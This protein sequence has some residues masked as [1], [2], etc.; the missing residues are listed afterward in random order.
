MKRELLDSPLIKRALD[1]ID[2]G[3][4]LLWGCVV[5]ATASMLYRAMNRG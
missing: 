1:A 2:I 5:Y 3:Y 4:V